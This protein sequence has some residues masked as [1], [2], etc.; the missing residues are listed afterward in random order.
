M[1]VDEKVEE[2]KKLLSTLSKESLL[3]WGQH[4]WDLRLRYDKVPEI[5]AVLR[6][7]TN[8]LVDHPDNDRRAFLSEKRR[9]LLD[10][11]WDFVSRLYGEKVFGGIGETI[12][13]WCYR[14]LSDHLIKENIGRFTK[15]DESAKQFLLILPNDKLIRTIWSMSHV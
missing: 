12:P 11:L 2:I 10:E 7:G 6:P 5:K 3:I 9:K 1:S 8:F 14:C 15:Y 13:K 4:L